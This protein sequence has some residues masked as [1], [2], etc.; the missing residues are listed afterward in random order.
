MAV[1]IGS[2]RSDE[3]GKLK[4]GKA[5]DQT[6][7]EVSTQAFYMHSK[8]W[9]GLRLKDA[10]KAEELAKAMKLA[11]DNNHVGYDQNER[12]GVYNKGINTQQN[13][14]TDCSVLVRACLK[15][16]GINV[17]NFTT[18][19]E[20][21]VLMATGLFDLVKVNSVNDVRNGDILVTRSKGH[22]VIVISGA[23]RVI[24]QPT[25]APQPT[26]TYNQDK[27]IADVMAIL[28]VPTKTNALASTVTISAKINQHHPLVTPLERYMKALG[29][30]TGS[31]EADQGKAPSFGNGMTNAIKKY[32]KD[33]VKATAKNQ[34]GEVTKRGATWRKLLGL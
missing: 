7:N 30:Y 23:S 22:T 17:T 12:L 15:Y 2:A 26:G 18:A 10:N 28:K 31:I 19:N 27:F 13:T 32:Q 5:G 8:G 1:I 34:D 4:G 16:I 20:K 3:R 14:E 11:C 29:Y 6:G 24:A 33:I 25:P 21:S 9:Y